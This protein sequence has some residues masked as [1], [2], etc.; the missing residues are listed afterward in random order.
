MTKERRNILV[1]DD[2]SD[3]LTV[4]GQAVKN[5]EHMGITDNIFLASD[6]VE[7][8]KICSKIHIHALVTDIK[9]PNKSGQELIEEL[10]EKEGSNF[11]IFV[12]TAYATDSITQELEQ[13]N[14]VKV[15]KK[16]IDIQNLLTELSDYLDKMKS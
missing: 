2:D 1:V 7:A 11:P 3:L 6:G 8:A 10:R 14:A 9:M 13:I 12:M 16:P 15:Y 5:L 4:M